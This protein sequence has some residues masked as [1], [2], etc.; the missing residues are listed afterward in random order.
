MSDINT[1]KV[2]GN[3]VSASEFNQLAE[4]DN[5]ISTSG[6][7]PSTSNLEQQAIASARYS[8][9][10]NFFTDSGTANAYVLSPVSPFKS[11]VSSVATETYF[12]GMVIR[13]RAG[14]ACSGASTVNVNNAGSKSLVKSSG[15]A[16]TTGDIPANT[17]VE[18]VY[19]GTN[20]V[21][22]LGKVPATTTT[23]GVAFL[24]NPITIANNATDANNDIDFSAGNAPLDDG[25]G[26]VLLSSTLVKR[27]DAT[28][29]AGTNQGGLFSGTKAINTWYYIFAIVNTTTGATDGGFDA[30][31][32]GAN[33]PSGWKISKILHAIKTDGTGSGNI[34]Q[35]KFYLDGW[36]YFNS[37]QQEYTSTSTTAGT[38]INLSFAPKDIISK[39]YLTALA[40]NNGTQGNRDFRVGISSTNSR[41]I[42]GQVSYGDTYRNKDGAGLPTTLSGGNPQVY[43]IS[44]GSGTSTLINHGFKLI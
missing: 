36:F 30:S 44:S 22:S 34:L 27:L 38:F 42:G 18:F 11:P 2:D 24:S 23:Q 9:A 10:G 3:T 35:G 33:V 37:E 26:Q 21:Q 19:N 1:S 25:S 28:W 40:T 31:V 41:I 12:N 16:L 39:A 29:S 32:S 17:E 43:I 4:I 8:S 7:T 15:S 20:F 6:Q 5:L 13:F 14:N